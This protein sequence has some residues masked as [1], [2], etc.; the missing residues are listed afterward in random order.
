[1]TL[2]DLKVTEAVKRGT[3]LNYT[4]SAQE[5]DVIDT[6]Y[7]YLAGNDSEIF[8]I[9]P[10]VGSIYLNQEV[11]VDPGREYLV[12]KPILVVSDGT[13]TDSATI[14][15][16]V[17]DYND[18]PPICNPSTAYLSIEENSSGAGFY[19][20]NCTD[21]DSSYNNNNLLSYSSNN[22]AVFSVDFSGVVSRF[23]PFDYETATT[24][25]VIIS[26]Q[27]QSA[28]NPLSTSVTV[29]VSS[30]AIQITPVNDNVPVWSSWLPAISESSSYSFNE[31]TPVGTI[32]FTV[33]ATDSDVTVGGTITYSIESIKNGSISV[34]GVFGIDAKT[35]QVTLQA[36]FD[37]DGVNGLSVYTVN[38][39]ATDGAGGSHTI[40]KSVNISVRDYNDN[41]PVF[42]GTPYITQYIHEVDTKAGQ[43]VLLLSALDQ[44]TT[45]SVLTYTVDTILVGNRTC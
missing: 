35:G 21:R 43:L 24:E 11:D 16:T 27:D 14:T 25:T 3:K 5:P 36:N 29:V 32:L 34:P 22:S 30:I 23:A 1:M 4:F 18:N 7:V 6:D 9:F 39:Q 38:F 31:N 28:T 20:L 19:T 33:V 10:L 8:N 37:T 26:I 45:P 2:A 42:L 12:F 15:L 44:D 13:F 41:A 40:T 17:F